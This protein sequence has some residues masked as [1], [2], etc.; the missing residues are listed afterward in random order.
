MW[1]GYDVADWH[2]SQGKQIKNWKQKAYQVWFKDE[3]KISASAQFV[4]SRQDQALERPAPPP[5][6]SYDQQRR[7]ADEEA[8]KLEQQ[9]RQN[10]KE[11]PVII[12]GF[13]MPELKGMP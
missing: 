10:R 1:N 5:W 4:P 9:A 3:N 12:P 11:A 6:K 2:D 8:H 7:E 13:K